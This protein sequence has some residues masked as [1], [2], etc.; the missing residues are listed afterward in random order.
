MATTVKT[1]VSIQKT[2]FEQ[3]E[4]LAK[5]LNI[6]RSHLFGIAI[7]KFI[8]NHQNQLLLDE[9]NQAY[10]DQPDPD[11]QD[12]LANLRQQQRR[13]VEGEW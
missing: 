10:D 4:S 8:K 11:E 1:A 12:R 2:L 5:E 7:E 3:A 6:S 13:L 9:L